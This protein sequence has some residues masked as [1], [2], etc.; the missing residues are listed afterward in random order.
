MIS[1]SNIKRAFRSMKQ[2]TPGSVP[3]CQM[4]NQHTPEM[5]Q[6]TFMS[7]VMQSMC[8]QP[9]SVSSVH[10]QHNSSLEMAGGAGPASQSTYA[11]LAPPSA[12]A[13]TGTRD[14]SEN[15]D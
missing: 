11:N 12:A 14:A 10:S 2:T 1:Y 9:S 7:P 8:A 13:S 15:I 5:Q 4:Q 3:S 6:Q